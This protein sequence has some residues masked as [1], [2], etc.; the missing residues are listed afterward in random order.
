MKNTI[1]RQSMTREEVT[2][3]LMARLKF[4]QIFDYCC[5]LILGF[6]I[7]ITATVLITWM[8]WLILLRIIGGEQSL[9]VGGFYLLG[10]FICILLMWIMAGK[11]THVYPCKQIFRLQF[12]L[13]TL[14][15][16]ERADS[17]A[18]DF[19]WRGKFLQRNGYIELAVEDFHEAIRRAKCRWNGMPTGPNGLP[20]PFVWYYAWEEDSL[21]DLS[22]TVDCFR[23]QQICLNK[24]GIPDQ[25]SELLK[26]LE[27]MEIEEF[28]AEKDYASSPSV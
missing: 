10:F 18:Q 12:E 11:I 16:P 23:Q 21:R 8:A 27:G 28:L 24:L 17:I 1:I 13:D 6:G 25:D 7:A 2:K 22:T 19:Y 4:Q 20:H 9:P 15:F 3:R 5:C 14:L 26:V